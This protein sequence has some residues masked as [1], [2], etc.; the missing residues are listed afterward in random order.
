[1]YILYKNPIQLDTLAIV[2]FIHFSGKPVI[3]RYCVEINHP[4]WVVNLPSIEEYNGNRHV[5][6]NEVVK[7]YESKTGIT[8]LLKKSEE[9]SNKFPLYTINS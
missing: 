1:M 8:D 2:R 5:G 7:Y 3:P 9:F 4:K 6:I